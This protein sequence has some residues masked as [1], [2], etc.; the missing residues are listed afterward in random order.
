MKKRS[1]RTRGGVRWMS[2]ARNKTALCEEQT[3]RSTRS[4]LLRGD[5][6]A[7]LSPSKYRRSRSQV[8]KTRLTKARR[9][10]QG[11]KVPGRLVAEHAYLC[12]SY[13]PPTVATASNVAYRV[14]SFSFFP[15]FLALTDDALFVF[16]P[17]EPVL[18]VAFSF[19]MLILFIYFLL[20]LVLFCFFRFFVL[21][22]ASHPGGA[23]PRCVSISRLRLR[24]LCLPLVGLALLF[25][26]Y[27]SGYVLFS[28]FFFFLFYFL[29][30]SL[31]SFFRFFSCNVP[32]IPLGCWLVYNML[33][34]SYPVR[35]AWDC[36]VY[37]PQ[38]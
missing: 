5:A 27:C 1:A 21:P 10:R 16:V 6:A 23:R 28:L 24:T 36:I 29:S 9:R 31:F 35:W 7:I 30:S 2:T 33:R 11:S 12:Y 26:L 22:V 20:C 4:H 17:G 19:C 38:Y 37:Y 3:P 13:I 14:T 18:G 8:R 34:R 32:G 15:V 25:M